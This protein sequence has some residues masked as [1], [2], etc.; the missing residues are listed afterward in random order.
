MI[1]DPSGEL[2]WFH[3]LPGDEQVF[4]FR[5]QT[6][7]GKPVLT[8]WQGDVAL[9]RGSGTGHILDDH[10]MP[11]AEVNAGNGYEMDAHEFQL[12]GHDT[13]LII[14]YAPTRWDLTKLGGRKDGIVEDNVVAGDRRRDR[15][16][17]VRV[18]RARAPSRSPSR[19]GPPRPRR[20]STT[21]R[22]TS[23]RS[24]RPRAAT[25]SSPPATRARSTRSTATTGKIL[26]RLGGKQSDFELGPGVEFHLQHDVR[27]GAGRQALAVRQ[28]RRGPPGEGPALARP[29]A[30]ARREGEDGR[31]SCRSTSTR[32]RCSPARRDRWSRST[33]AGAFV[34]WGGM[35]PFFT[36]FDS[37][38][39]ATFDAAFAAEG[40]ES[41]RAYALPVGGARRRPARRDGPARRRRAPSCGRAGTAR[42]TSRAG[43]SATS[44]C[45]A[46]A[47]RRSSSWR[48]RRPA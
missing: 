17:A 13:A 20:A 37:S 25:S 9:Y 47:S 34:G 5:T 39:Q 22:S 29:G 18:A 19:S 4:D 42:R 8:Y 40:V 2:V 43:G 6:Y 7:R 27:P 21:T 33:A 23:T 41:Y 45:R 10:Y 26:W 44:R 28:R 38:G 46:P 48:A 15:R 1:L 3:P 35:Q 11:V 16:R 36:E 24:R 32:A 14:S 12:T 30:R 31:A